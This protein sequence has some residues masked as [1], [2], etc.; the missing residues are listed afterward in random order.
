MFDWLQSAEAHPYLEHAPLIAFLIWIGFVGACVGSFLNVVYHRVPRGE[1]IVVRGSHC[2]VCDHPIRWRHNLPI[3][4][5]LM[6]RGRC[7]DCGAPIPIRYWLFEL[8]FG[9]LFALAGWW[10]WPG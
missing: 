3:F 10:F 2:P 8:F 7:Y 4:G 5:W 1:D 9:A 6:L